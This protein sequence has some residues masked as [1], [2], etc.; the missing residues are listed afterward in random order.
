MKPEVREV[1][2]LVGIIDRWLDRFVVN[3]PPD[4]QS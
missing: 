1:R 4:A 2:S 3:L